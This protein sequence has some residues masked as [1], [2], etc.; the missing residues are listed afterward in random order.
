MIARL[1]HGWTERPQA[2]TYEELLKHEILPGIE[3]QASGYKGV[4]VL[5]RDGDDRVEFVTVTLWDSVEAVREFIGD[6]YEVA[7]VPA[8][9][10]KVLASYDQ[11][12]VHY[13]VVL[14]VP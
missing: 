12:S 5:R 10:R 9:A 14:S 8:E 3:K 6:D 11:R 13:E 4:Q 7:Y 2:E 1:W